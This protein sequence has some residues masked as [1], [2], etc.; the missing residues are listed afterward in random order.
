MNTT[1]VNNE[2][3]QERLDYHVDA[4]Y[5]IIRDEL[6]SDCKEAT[7]LEE[8]LSDGENLF[9]HYMNQASTLAEDA[10]HQ[11]EGL[12]THKEVVDEVWTLY[13]EKE[14]L[15]EINQARKEK[16]LTPFTL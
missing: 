1:E 10:I 15:E 11:E 13:S 7:T 12:L 14:L 8:A 16:N 4:I 9:D 2:T 5:Y 6:I 3:K